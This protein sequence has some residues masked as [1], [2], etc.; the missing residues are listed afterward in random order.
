MS[1]NTPQRPDG[2]NES[3]GA[4]R[5]Q[6][7]P[8]PVKPDEVSQTTA[9]P[10]AGAHAA[11]EPSTEKISRTVVKT[12]TKRLPVFLSALGGLAVGAVLVIA[13]V[14]TG[15]L[16]INRDGGSVSANTPAGTQTIQID[17]EDTTLAEAVSAKALPS[18]V[19]IE[20]EVQDTSS[21]MSGGSSSSGSIG[22]GVILDSDGNIL[23][24]YHVVQNATSIVV[25]L[26]DGSSYEAEIV[27]SDESSDLAVIRLV[28]A[29]PNALTPIE[30]G[31]SD[32][33]TVGSW[34]MA[35]GSP[36]GNEQSVSTGI[37]SALYRST[38]MQSTTGTTIYANMIQT[39]AAINPGNSG[40]ALVNDN[41]ELVGI[42]SIIES[43]SG[44]SSG[45]GF[46]IPV[47]YAKNIADQ[48]IAGQTP[49]HSYLGVSLTTV[50]ALNARQNNLSV[51]YGAYINEVTEG[52]PAAEAGMQAGDIV[53]A[54]NGD[55]ITSADGLIIALRGYD[56]GEK[57]TLTV[58]RGSEQMDLEVTL[59][60]DEALQEQQ[61]SSTDQNGQGS[62]SMS[63][64][65]LRE[66]LNEL[67]GQ[68][69]R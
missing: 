15:A 24:N 11:Q 22:S 27:G 56:V 69:G 16:D 23:T 17:A 19:S 60:S 31:D 40:G 37:V 32:E 25:T 54:A 10:N 48:I 36:F 55:E 53:I 7:E 64:E 9:M 14:M 33:L 51:D 8:T 2:L 67:L 46:A 57:V 62:N 34:V 13:L 28:N 39:D 6:V 29:D 21:M 4:P 58:M 44:S 68:G 49:V 65:Q 52:G 47:N 35:I 38:A 30:I 1:E 45:V 41:G 18:V 5:V 61:D 26:N 43:Y 12:R 59:G 66:L 63:E 50:N 3:T 20:T 42:N